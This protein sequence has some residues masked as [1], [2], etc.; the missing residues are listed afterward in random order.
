MTRAWGCHEAWLH[1]QINFVQRMMALFVDNSSEPFICKEG[2][3]LGARNGVDV[4]KPISV[5]DELLSGPS[6]ILIG[7]L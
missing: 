5:G 2:D 1:H 3:F 6:V 7:A 4:G